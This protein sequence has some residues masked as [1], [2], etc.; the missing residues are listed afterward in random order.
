MRAKEYQQVAMQFN[1]P[2]ATESLEKCFE[3]LIRKADG[4]EKYLNIGNLVHAVMGING[5]AGEVIDLTK[6]YIF[7]EK[8]VDLEH[9]KKEIGDIMWYIQLL[10]NTLGLDLED[11]VLQGNMDKLSARYPSGFNTYDANHRKQGDI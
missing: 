11:D 4:G 6:K 8:E 7:H 3:R 2:N 9:L 5:E 1:N 10:C